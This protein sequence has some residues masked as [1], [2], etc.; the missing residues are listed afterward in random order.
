V[1]LY[2][3]AATLLGGVLSLAIAGVVA[4]TL[5]PRWV[6]HMVS[7]AVGALLAVA[8]LDV[9]PEALRRSSS[10]EGLL[11]TLLGGLLLFFLLEKAAL[12]RHSHAG[13]DDDH[14]GHAHAHVHAEGHHHLNEAHGH[15]GHGGH[16][17]AAMVLIGDGFH[18]FVDG[19]L[20]AAA[21]TADLRLGVATATAVMIHEIP[22][23]I[24]DFMVLLSSGYSR[25]RALFWNFV[26]SLTA[27]A[28]GVLGYA[29]LDFTDQ[30][31]PYVLAMASASF[32]YVAMADLIP[33]MQRRW[34]ASA[35]VWQVFLILAGI[36]SIAAMHYVHV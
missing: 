36:A 34:D 18:N 25:R 11:A 16:A 35:A 22:Q 10:I 29:L 6:G 20:I 21:F 31:L 15:A 17:T 28:G 3:I 1:L 23:E 2:I 8:F 7:F 27:V 9:L 19:I 13:A 30:A 33:G 14:E 32:I 4:L 5:L 12:W 26:S 24:G